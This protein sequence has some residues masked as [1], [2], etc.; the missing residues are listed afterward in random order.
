MGAENR[1]VVFKT[2]YPGKGG[3]LIRRARPMGVE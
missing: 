3:S 2:P 1:G